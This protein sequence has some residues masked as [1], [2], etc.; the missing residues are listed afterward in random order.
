MWLWRSGLWCC[1]CRAYRSRGFSRGRCWLRKSLQN[2]SALFHAAVHANN[3]RQRANHEHHRAPRGRLRKHRS[4]AARAK[5][6]LAACAAERAGQI[7]RFAALQ[8]YD[9]N[10][11]QAVQ[12]KKGGQQPRRPTEPHHNNP[13]THDQ[14]DRPFHPSWHFW[15]PNLTYVRSPARASCSAEL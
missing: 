6:R 4:G 10:Q 1:R 8:Q 9:D 14:R 15:H 7:S 13:E 12:H 11:H 3:H 2:R 5:R